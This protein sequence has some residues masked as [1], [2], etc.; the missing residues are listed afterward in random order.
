[1]IGILTVHLHLPACSSLKEKRRRLRPLLSRL[2]REFNVAVAEMGHQDSWQEAIISCATVGND[3]A[4]LQ[5]ALNSVGR[6]LR[7]NWPDGM[8]VD[9]RI[10]LI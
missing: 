6:W 1:M 5:S 2:H 4:Y 7:G 9:T 3:Q 8:V 10:E